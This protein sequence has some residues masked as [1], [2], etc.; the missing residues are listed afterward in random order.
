[1]RRVTLS[2]DNGPD[3][4]VTPR[5]LDILRSRD[6]IAQ[7]YVLGKH[8]VDPAG[9]RLVARAHAEGHVVGNHSFT[10]AT[11]LGK[12]PRSDAVAQEIVATETLLSP[13]VPGPKYFRP[14]GGGGSLGPHL[15][16]RS[17]VGY[18]VAHGYTCALW[19]CVPRDW[20]EPSTWAARALSDCATR[21]HTVVALHDI[22]HACLAGLEHFIDTARAR[23][24]TFVPD[25]P[26]ACTPIL[27]GRVVGD[28]APVLAAPRPPRER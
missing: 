19:N 18:L 15:L 6:V 24:M 7:F 9:Q 25:L 10:H 23:G 3:P 27:H 21:D 22:P 1:M 2:F 28:L 12:D 14:F 26:L 5:V 13:L 11:P 8:L 20:V 4:E 16:S 17:A